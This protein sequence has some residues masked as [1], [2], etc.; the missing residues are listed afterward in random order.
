M[1]QTNIGEAFNNHYRQKPENVLKHFECFVKWSF[2]CAATIL[3]LI[4]EWLII[5]DEKVIFENKYSDA[6]YKKVFYI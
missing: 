2:I 4:F 3:I 5:Y 6:V 1:I